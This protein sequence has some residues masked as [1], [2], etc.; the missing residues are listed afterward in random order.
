M[1]EVPLELRPAGPILYFTAMCKNTVQ[2]I[3]S[4]VMFLVTMT[5]LAAQVDVKAVVA[6]LESLETLA[7]CHIVVNNSSTGTITNDDGYFEIRDLANSDTLW[8]SYIGYEV[9][10]IS[11]REVRGLDTLFLKALSVGIDELTVYSDDGFLYEAIAQCSKVMEGQEAFD[12]RVYFFLETVD[13]GRPLE[14]L[15]GYYN[16]TTRGASILTFELKNGRV[17]WPLQHQGRY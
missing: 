3:F 8:V 2:Y 13:G 4:T 15:E 16:S 9:L 17:G 6:D 1:D 10:A 5:G 14:M 12:S 7:Y 11:V